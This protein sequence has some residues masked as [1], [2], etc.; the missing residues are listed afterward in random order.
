LLTVAIF[1]I[2]RSWYKREEKRNLKEG[3]DLRRGKCGATDL[4]GDNWWET[5]LN[6][7]EAVSAVKWSG[8]EAKRRYLE[9]VFN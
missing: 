3:V 8:R 1:L 9:R 5:T 7:G 2:V 6:E 4:K